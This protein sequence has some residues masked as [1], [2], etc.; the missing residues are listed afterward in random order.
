MSVV[1]PTPPLVAAADN[2]TGADIIFPCIIKEQRQR[3]E[4][5]QDAKNMLKSS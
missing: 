5:I 1:L 2:I 4:V 3:E